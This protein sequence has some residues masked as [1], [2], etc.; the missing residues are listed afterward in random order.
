MTKEKAK[1]NRLTRQTDRGR[2]IGILQ[3]RAHSSSDTPAHAQRTKS[4]EDCSGKL[5][6]MS[7]PSSGGSEGKAGPRA[8]TKDAEKAAVHSS[9]T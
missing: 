8:L 4:R 3:R 7:N 2:Q 1:Q 5:L 6:C 9:L